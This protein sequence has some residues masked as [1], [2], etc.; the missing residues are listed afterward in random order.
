MSERYDRGGKHVQDKKYI[1]LFDCISDRKKKYMVDRRIW[2]VNITVYLEVNKCGTQSV[3]V[4]LNILSVLRGALD[5]NQQL[6]SSTAQTSSSSICCYYYLVF[7]L[8]YLLTRLTSEFTYILCSPITQVEY[9]PTDW[10]CCYIWDYRLSNSF[11]MSCT[12]CSGALSVQ[13]SYS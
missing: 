13:T 5:Q 2:K 6:P 11:H 4:W 7:P 12:L 8:F 10:Y 9:N 3:G 1:Q